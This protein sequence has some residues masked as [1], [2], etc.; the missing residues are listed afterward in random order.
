MILYYLKN[1]SQEDLD[2]NILYVYNS[3]RVI[4]MNPLLHFLLSK[5]VKVRLA[6]YLRYNFDFVILR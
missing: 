6:E 3:R 5:N 4:F 2:R 1:T